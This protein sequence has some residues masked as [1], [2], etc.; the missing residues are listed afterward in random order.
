MIN[1]ALPRVGFSVLFVDFSLTLEVA[2]YVQIPPVVLV[3]V[4]MLLF[5]QFGQLRV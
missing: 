3:I 5:V 1:N 2:L 4:V